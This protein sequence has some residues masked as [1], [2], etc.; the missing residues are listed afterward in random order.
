MTQPRPPIGF[1]QFFCESQLVFVSVSVRFRRYESLTR[2][3][4]G[5]VFA[6]TDHH[7]RGRILIKQLGYMQY[8]NDLNDVFNGI[9]EFSALV[10][11][12]PML[13]H[14]KSA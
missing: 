5:N 7:F 10:L 13:I 3:V 1:T 2:Q 4:A 11:P 14:F 8:V 6:L 12:K 9:L